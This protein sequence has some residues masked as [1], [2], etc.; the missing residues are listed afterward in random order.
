MDNIST[1]RCAEISCLAVDVGGTKSLV[2]LVD[3]HG[4][5]LKSKKYA[6]VLSTSSVE[7]PVLD[8][9]CANIDDFIHCGGIP[10]TAVAMAVGIV[11]RIDY[12]NGIWLQIDPN[13]GGELPLAAIL[14]HKYGLPCA[15]DNDVHC[16]VAAEN[17][18]GWGRKSQDYVYINVGTGIAAGFI[19][20]GTLIRGASF[21]AGEVGHQVVNSESDVKCPVC[22]RMGCVE[23]IASGAGMDQRARS[24]KNIYPD[25]H[26]RIPE[27][28]KCDL[29]EVF[30]LAR[31]GDPMC[32]LIVSDAVDAIANLIMNLVRTTDPDTIILGGGVVSDGFLL[33]QIKAKLNATTMR[34]VKNGV[35]LTELDP[36]F[37]GLIGAGVVGLN[38]YKR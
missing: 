9:V 3:A 36:H 17:A 16:A 8:A 13:R 22:G 5:V 25:S 28:T 12:E 38:R 15:I 6:S 37:V 7:S 34:F 27:D 31:E 24:L 23:A 20:N 33:P 1:Q 26:L 2:G 11:G 19:V 4:K 32:R 29:R 30:E 35:L 21:N 14:T 18:L 10:E